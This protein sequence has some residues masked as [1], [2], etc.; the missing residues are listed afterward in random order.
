MPCVFPVLSI[1]ALS[2]VKT[3]DKHP[4]QAKL[5]GLAYT[6]GVVLSFVGIAALLLTL[7][8]A[9]AEIGWGFQ[10]QNPTV[11]AFLAYLLF[12][13]SLNLGG[14]FD[15]GGRFTNAGN[16]LTQGSSLTNSFFTGIL[17][18]IVAAPCTAPFMAAAIG[19]AL[20]Q[21]AFVNLTVFAALGF[22]L[23]LPYLLLSFIPALRH[24]LPKPGAWMETF[25]QFLAFPMLL[26]AVWLVW[27]LSQ[28]SGPT[29]VL[30]ILTGMT[31]LTFG[32]W[33]F[34]H[35]PAK[36]PQKYLI[37]GLGILSIFGAL[38]LGI[39]EPHSAENPAISDET[40]QFGEVFSPEKLETLLAG[41]DPIFVEM[42]AAWCITCKVNHAVA[43]NTKATRNLFKDQNV[44]Y[45][46][47]DWTNQDP[48]ITQYLNDY[49]RNGVPLYVYYGPKNKETEE[50][51]KPVILPQILNPGIINDVI[52][53]EIE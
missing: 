25:K 45:L 21:S 7:K 31:L 3:A 9:G 16:K 39:K 37:L 27:V 15:I 44:Q 28:Q 42:T 17:A 20:T 36:A 14:F 35:K 2:L 24:I 19:F 41:K 8:A 6:A 18:T 4:N 29:G 23:A 38:V 12:L 22:G 10:L 11:I 48:V 51:P 50:R 33:L 52:T 32:I 47:G 1:K 43:I 46:I 5:H 53:Q 26:S 34:K 30:E 40:Q 13:I 49:G